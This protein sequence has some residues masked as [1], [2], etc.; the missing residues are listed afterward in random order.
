MRRLRWAALLELLLCS[1]ALAQGPAAGAPATA[2]GGAGPGAPAARCTDPLDASRYGAAL[3][4]TTDDSRAM[5]AARVAAGPNGTIHV[6]PG[7][8]NTTSG[9]DEKAGAPGVRL[10]ALSG[11]TYATGGPNGVPVNFVG[12]DEVESVI[13]GGKYL[14]RSNFGSSSP[15]LRID[16]YYNPVQDRDTIGGTN[17]VLVVDATVAGPGRGRPR[18]G[19]NGIW[20]NLTQLDDDAIGLQQDV[21]VASL[22]K[23]DVDALKDGQ[24]PR[25][26]LW[27]ANFVAQSYDGAPSSLDGSLVALEDDVYGGDDDED[28]QGQTRIALHIIAAKSYPT[29]HEMRVKYAVLVGTGPGAHVGRAFATNGQFDTAGFDSSAAS[30]YAISYA[31]SAAQRAAGPTLDLGTDGGVRPGMIATGPGIPANDIVVAVR[32]ESY[33]DNSVQGAAP[34]AGGTVTLAHPTQVALASGTRIAFASEAPAFQ[35]GPTQ[36]LCFA[37]NTPGLALGRACAS[38]NP[39]TRRIE[40]ADDALSAP[41]LAAGPDGTRIDAPVTLGAGETVNRTARFT[42]EARFGAG[43]VDPEPGVARAIKASGNGIAWS[44]GAQGDSL[45][46]LGGV[47]TSRTASTRL[48]PADC[49]TTIRDT[50][51]TAHTYTVGPG[52]APGCRIDV[53]Q[54]GDGPVTFAGATGETVEQMGA[55][56]AHRT[57]GRF[58]QATLLVDSAATVLLGGQV[59]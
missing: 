12:S 14:G 54:A 46:L 10:W 33:A 7:G 31:T 44:G 29:D 4:G 48:V 43:Y 21:A 27:G 42:A 8:W 30:P 50:A 49:G 55:R 15:A 24:G 45:R 6:P 41:F 9:I 35:M 16:G 34:R 3:D 28:T 32:R 57:A 53:I 18:Y 52:L 13:N 22:A 19:T 20:A 23:R 1:P 5:T 59:Q 39:A 40:F 2:C 47:V 51:A 17:Q 36:R 26:E 25:A 58:A 11:N 38:F 37:T 56:P